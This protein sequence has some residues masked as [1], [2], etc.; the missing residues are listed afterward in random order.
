VSIRDESLRPARTR[1]GELA[2]WSGVAGYSWVAGRYPSFTWQATVAV[3][4]P[5]IAVFVA[6]VLA[7]SRLPEP[8][9]VGR[10]AGVIWSIPVGAFCLL[11]IVDDMLGSTYEHPTLSSLMDPVLQVH[12]FRSIAIFCWLAAGWQLVKR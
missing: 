12:A 4:L 1:A 11:E 5:G 7:P 10:R 9:R 6:G 8:R 3:L 2:A